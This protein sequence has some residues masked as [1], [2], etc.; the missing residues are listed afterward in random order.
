MTRSLAKGDYSLLL[1]IE[2]SSR[3]DSFYRVLADRQS[4]L[5]SCDCPPWLFNRGGQSANGARSCDH[6]LL[7]QRLIGAPV[8]AAT[9]TRRIAAGVASPIVAAI[10]QQWPGLHGS[11]EVEAARGDIGD[12]AYRFYLVRFTPG[13]GGVVTG[14]VAFCER[15]Q[16]GETF[17]ASRVA[18]WAGYAIAAELARRGGYPLAGQP[19]EHFHVPARRTVRPATATPARPARPNAAPMVPQIGLHD[20]LRVGDRV[21]LG[22]GLQPAQRAENTLRLFL[23]EQLYAKLESQHF[24][25]VSSITHA[26]VQRVYRLRRDPRKRYDRRIRVF[27]RGRYVRDYCVIRERNDIPEGDQW[28]ALFLGLMADEEH[29]LS[30]VGSYNIFDPFSDGDEQETEPAEWRP[31]AA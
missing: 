18:A 22:D 26:D 3:R 28:M 8:A 17:I 14:V 6:T 13:N 9:P 23:G 5:L 12:K 29:L 20:I 31:Q 27:E 19:P 21:D 4:G 11:W 2:S 30:V 24:L 7:T 16:P 25:D 10:Q 15:H 1:A